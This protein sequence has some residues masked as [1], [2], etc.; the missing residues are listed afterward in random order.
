[1]LN[2]ILSINFSCK[3]DV[4]R[5]IDRIVHT[6]GTATRTGDALQFMRRNSFLSKNGGREVVT[7]V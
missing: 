2:C 1:M 7:K 6:G 4:R 5:A 3:H